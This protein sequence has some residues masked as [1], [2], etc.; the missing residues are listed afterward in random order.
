MFEAGSA[1]FGRSPGQAGR[2]APRHGRGRRPQLVVRAA[3]AAGELE[4]AEAALAALERSAAPVGTAPM[5]GSLWLAHGAVLRARGRAPEAADAHL[6][7]ATPFAAAG[8]TFDAAQA[9]LQQ[10]GALR[11]AGRT[12]EAE[13]VAGQARA[14]LGHLDP[15]AASG[16]T[17]REREVLR[18]LASGRFGLPG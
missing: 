2:P 1:S 9:R 11:A 6:K 15:P 5:L 13:A 8:A 4:E 18:L 17:V 14:L 7:A 3:A 12:E 16:V 10:A